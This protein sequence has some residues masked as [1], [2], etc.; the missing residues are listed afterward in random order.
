MKSNY[1]WIGIAFS[2]SLQLGEFYSFCSSSSLSF[3][4]VSN[5]PI[6][7]SNSCYFAY[8]FSYPNDMYWLNFGFNFIQFYSLKVLG[9]CLSDTAFRWSLDLNRSTQALAPLFYWL[10]LCTASC[11]LSWSLPLLSA[12]TYST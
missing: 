9:M 3:F 1:L 6:S 11:I 5:W 8:L 4:R 12:Y 7:S 2:Y 10:I